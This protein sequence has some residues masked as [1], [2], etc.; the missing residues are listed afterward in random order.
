MV[1]L[2]KWR[3]QK[4]CSGGKEASQARGYGVAKN[5]TLHAAR[6]GSLDFARD[7]LFAAQ[8]RLAQD[9]KSY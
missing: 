2:W 3:C 7:R 9:D 4:S 6:P 8:T 5:A 1:T